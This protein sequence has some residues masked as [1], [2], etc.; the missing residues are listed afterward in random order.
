M[1]GLKTSLRSGLQLSADDLIAQWHQ[2]NGPK[3][4]QVGDTVTVSPAGVT[5]T[6][7]FGP[8]DGSRGG[9]PTRHWMIRVKDDPFPTLRSDEDM[10]LA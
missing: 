7:A 5:G 8:I 4:F 6:I 9:P 1:A 10:S 3:D 2:R